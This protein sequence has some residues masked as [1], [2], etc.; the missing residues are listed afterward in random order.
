MFAFSQKYGIS[1]NAIG[2]ATGTLNIEGSVA[3][4]NKIS[5]HLPVMWNPFSFNENKK[6]KHIALQPGMR[7]WTWHSYSGTFFGIYS[8]AI[9]FNTGLNEHRYSGKAI[10]IGLSA[11]Y[12]KMLS[13]N[14]NIEAELGYS[15]GYTEYETFVRVQCGDYVR[16][17]KGPIHAPTKASISIMYIF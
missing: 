2:L 17:Y 15:Y 10:G 9:S 13:K 16:S 5:F 11:G 14:L 4:S 6:I 7:F 8:T 1:S 12:A 3:T